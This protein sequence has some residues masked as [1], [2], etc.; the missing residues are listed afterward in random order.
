MGV[1]ARP[2]PN[3][4]AER[5]LRTLLEVNNAIINKLEQADLLRAICKSMRG[6]L[7]FDRSAITLYVPERDTLRISAQEGNV[8]SDYFVVGLE[9]DRTDSHSGWAFDRQRVLIRHDLETEAEFSSERRLLAEGVRSLCIAPLIVAA[10]SIGTLNLSSYSANQYSVSEGELLFEIA[11]QTALAVENMQAYEQIRGLNAQLARSAE[12]NRVLLEINNAIATSL[13]RE[14]LVHAICEATKNVV[15]FDRIALTLPDADGELLRMATFEGPYPSQHFSN[16]FAYEIDNSNIGWA[17]RHQKYLIRRDLPTEAEYPSEYPA[18]AEGIHS[19]CSIPIVAHGKSIAAMN[20]ASRNR[21]QYSEAD[22]EFLM[23]VAR[24][25]A[26]AFENMHAYA[27]MSELSNRALQEATNRRQAEE[28]LRFVLEGTSS[29]T[30]ADFFQSMVRCLSS[31]LHVKYAFVTECLDDTKSRVRTLAFWRHQ[32]FGEN[33]E[34]DLTGTPCQGVFDGQICHHPENV[35]GLFPG[36]TGLAEWRAQSFLGIPIADRRGTVIGHLA[37]LDEGPLPDAVSAISVL[38]IFA[39]RASA[40]LL[41][42]RADANLHKALAEVEHLKNRLQ[43]ENVYLQDEIRTEHNF[44]ELVG[45][46][47]ALL[48]TLQKVEQVAPTDA[49]VL[50]LG[51]TG[52]GKELIAR[53]IHDRSRRSS[54]PLVKMNCGAIPAGLVE[55]ELFGHMKG[56]FTG[57]LASYTGRFAL[58]DGG[59]LFLDELS[60]LPLETQ[61]KLLRVL[62]EQEFEPVGSNKTRRVDVRIIASTNRNLERAV[63][64][65]RF[66]ADLFY[67]LNVFPL[68]LPPLRARREDIPHLVKFFLERFSKKF[69][70]TIA[71]VGKETMDLLMAYDWP[72]NVRELQNIIERA[73][74]LAQGSILYVDPLFLPSASPAVRDR[75][76]EESASMASASHPPP[77][78]QRPSPTAPEELPSLEEMERSHI[79]TALKRTRGVIEG[80]RGAA[81]ILNLHPNTLRSRMAKLGISRRNHEISR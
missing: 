49:T 21:N 74:V 78:P 50:V 31:A 29:L 77:V 6:V 19:V 46:S 9:T 47:R 59:T 3:A 53:A 23:E 25:I 69:G 61:V 76:A 2:A 68:E 12:H 75:L 10:R 4:V 42:M 40:E 17:F 62:Q 32:D 58:A 8:R 36:D 44:S 38:K 51:E 15:P 65:G 79:L 55:S 26:I 56:A 20:V 13:D 30:G 73:V 54:R 39:A 71:A 37:V 64:E 34:Y 67:R 35:Q 81:K 45:S 14:E 80:A 5:R 16:G 41:R 52:T 24:Q 7:P 57:A 22:A 66:R 48:A 1:P 70:K 28:T 63:S 27:R 72:G 33:F 18:I 43:Q 60:E 11:K